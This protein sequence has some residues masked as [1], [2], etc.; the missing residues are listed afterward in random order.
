MVFQYNKRD[1][2]NL[3]SIELLNKTLNPQK[4][5]FFEA[6]A[7]T[8]DG[9]IETLREISSLTLINI[10]KAIEMGEIKAGE[11][12]AIEFDTNRE[13]QIIK[14]EELPYKKISMEN[15]PD[16]GDH[17]IELELKKEELVEE[18]K[19]P[20]PQMLVKEIKKNFIDNLSDNSRITV[21][22]KINVNESPLNIEIK[23]NESKILESFN[24]DINSE[25]KKITIILDVKK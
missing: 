7:L 18:K 1:L 13:Q 19:P 17:N 5:T 15:I 16:F 6:V 11:K 3:I 8:G 25:V 22:K 10:K 2:K 4:M 20:P 24:L 12:P 21:I 9:V 23:D 14:K